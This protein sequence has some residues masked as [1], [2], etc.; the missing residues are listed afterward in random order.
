MTITRNDLRSADMDAESLRR[1]YGC[2]PSGVSAICA[3]VDGSPIGMAAS[4]FTA[5]SLDP[6]LLSV[7]IQKTSAT[8]PLLRRQP[9]L[10]LSILAESHVLAC[11]SL[12]AKN[13]DRFADVNWDADSDGAIYVDDAV[14]QFSTKCVSELSAGDHLIVLLEI[15]SMGCVPS[16][17]PLIFHSSSYRRLESAKQLDMDIAPDDWY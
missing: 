6:P 2:F 5:V 13:G 7:C 9:R 8:W 3:M 16:A 14:A 4:S 1:A 10:G 17:A 12:S 15:E 11:N